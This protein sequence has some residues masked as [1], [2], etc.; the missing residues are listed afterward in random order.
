MVCG[1]I[2]DPDLIQ[3]NPARLTRATDFNGN[4]C[5]RTAGFKDK[6]YGYYLPSTSGKHSDTLISSFMA[7]YCSFFVQQFVLMNV[8]R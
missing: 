3:G 4:I 7:N 6:P 1:A 2:Y 5:G 8:Q